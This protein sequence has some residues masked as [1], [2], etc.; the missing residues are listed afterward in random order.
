M[1][2]LSAGSGPRFLDLSEERSELMPTFRSAYG[3]ETVDV[4]PKNAEAYEKA[5]WQLVGPEEKPKKADK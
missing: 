2:L 4:D 1:W 3:T 5:G